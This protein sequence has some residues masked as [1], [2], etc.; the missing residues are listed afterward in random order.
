MEERRPRPDLNELQS[1]VFIDPPGVDAL[2]P[3]Q[4]A[5]AAE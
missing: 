3:E 4:Y 1:R 5:R 2:S